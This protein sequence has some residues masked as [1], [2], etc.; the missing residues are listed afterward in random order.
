ML[1]Y[2][3]ILLC[4]LLCGCSSLYYSSMK[5]LGREKRYILVSRIQDG[6]K[7]QDQAAQQF[8]TA[9]EAFQE[10]TKF[11]GGDLEKIHKKLNKQLEDA[12][13]RAKKVHDRIESIDKVA[14][15]LFQE[16][17]GEI[18]KMSSG[19]LQ[20]ESRRLLR[21]ATQRHQ[22]LIRQMRSSEDKMAPVVQAFRDQVLFLK[23]NLNAR[24]IQSLKKS[25]LEIDDD[26][27]ALILDLEKSN[28]EADKTIAGLSAVTEEAS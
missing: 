6:K 28:Q 21:D 27:K 10:V 18:D 1:R 7:A 11:D 8:K 14:N 16:W 22:N 13:D 15:D 23:H 25:V 9:L 24:A 5:K 20:E 26:V 12:E 4:L 17:S 3:G 19:R 2:L